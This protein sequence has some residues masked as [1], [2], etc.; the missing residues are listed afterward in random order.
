LFLCT[1]PWFHIGS[2]LL[3]SRIA[4]TRFFKILLAC[5]DLCFNSPVPQTTELAFAFGG[6]VVVTEADQCYMVLLMVFTRRSCNHG[7]PTPS[8]FPFN[9][10]RHRR[11]Q[12]RSRR[13]ENKQSLLFASP[14]SH[15][16]Q[17]SGKILFARDVIRWKKTTYYSGKT[18]DN[19]PGTRKP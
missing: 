5:V 3:T 17:R 19:A 4:I 10:F 6:R 11:I 12:L 13:L 1:V 14:T 15:C 7:F 2:Q 18:T 8:L 16:Q 9:S